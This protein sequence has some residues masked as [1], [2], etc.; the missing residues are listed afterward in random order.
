PLDEFNVA[1]GLT[2]T[3][4]VD[5]AFILDISLAC[6]GDSTS[7]RRSP[8]R[9]FLVDFTWPTL[10]VIA[11]STKKG[12][13]PWKVSFSVEIL[14]ITKNVGKLFR[15]ENESIRC[16]LKGPGFFFLPIRHFY[17]FR[18]DGTAH[19]GAQHGKAATGSRY[20]QPRR[21]PWC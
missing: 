12:D 2:I 5:S 10:P 14:P 9:S 20:S 4:I 15:L 19:H 21:L 7:T 17:I 8:D 18:P 1:C 16:P 11:F 13:T 6:F 3:G